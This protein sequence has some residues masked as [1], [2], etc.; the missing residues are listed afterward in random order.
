MDSYGTAAG[1]TD[2]ELRQLIEKNFDFRLGALQ[3]AL[4]LKEPIFQR[5]AAYGHFGREELDLPW[6]QSKVLAT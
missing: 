2:T 1:K 4:A 6:E 5:L 3:Q